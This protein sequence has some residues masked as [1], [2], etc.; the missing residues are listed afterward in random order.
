MQLHDLPIRYMKK[1]YSEHI[2]SYIKRVTDVDVDLDDKVWGSCLRIRVE[3]NISKPF[4]LGRKKTIMGEEMW[5][6]V[7][8]EKLAKFCYSCWRIYNE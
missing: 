6:S 7:Y 1:S 5:I 4:A 3:L 2:G 8:Y